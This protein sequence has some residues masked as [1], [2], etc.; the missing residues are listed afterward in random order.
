MVVLVELQPK[1]GSICRS[2]EGQC[3][4]TISLP[5]GYSGQENMTISA[6]Q[7]HAPTPVAAQAVG[8]ADRAHERQKRRT[9]MDRGA[10]GKERP[11]SRKRPC[12]PEVS[13]ICE[14]SLICNVWGCF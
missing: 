6:E 3:G 14:A 11:R 2:G 12:I 1:Q 9:R 8:E 10:H 7:A 4:L 13:A 5:T